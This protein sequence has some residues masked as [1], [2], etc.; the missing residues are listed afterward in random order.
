M[1]NEE[2]RAW[3]YLVTA[4]GVVAVYLAVI[5][6]Q[7]PDKDAADI[8]YIRPMVTAIV[9]AIVINMVLTMVTTSGSPDLKDERDQRISRHGEFVAFYVMSVCAIVPLGLAMAEADYFWI[10]NTLYLSFVAAALASSV[11][12]IVAYRRGL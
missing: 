2:K 9:A 3:T 10:A 8:A 5:L 7:L 12:K 6:S 11:V 1:T 4:S